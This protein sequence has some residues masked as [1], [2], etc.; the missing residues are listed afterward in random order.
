MSQQHQKSDQIAF[1]F[2]TKLFYVVQEARGD[3]SAAV[4][5]SG[6]D[7]DGFGT[8]RDAARTLQETQHEIAEKA[9]ETAWA[10]QRTRTREIKGRR[11]INGSTWKRLTRTCCRKRYA[12]APPLPLEI[13]VLLQVPEL[14]NKDVLVHLGDTNGT[15]SSSRTPLIP[16]LRCILLETYTLEFVPWGLAG[17]SNTG[18]TSSGSTAEGLVGWLSSFTPSSLDER[19]RASFDDD[20]ALELDQDTDKRDEF[21]DTIEVNNLL[22]GSGC[23]GIN[24]EP[25][26]FGIGF[27]I[28]LDFM[29]QYHVN[30]S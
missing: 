3:E 10:A 14:N 13:Q 1:D 21:F 18:S 17:S 6:D 24:E 7:G 11:L 12:S 5:G 30:V 8:P 2:Y 29:L 16:T 20:A 19:P 25:R 28:D 27:S 26:L 22:D 9:G 4:E 15:A 23:G